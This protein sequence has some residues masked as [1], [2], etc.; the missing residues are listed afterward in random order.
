[1]SRVDNNCGGDKGQKPLRPNI[2]EEMM[3]KKRKASTEVVIGM[4]KYIIHHYKSEHKVF[5]KIKRGL[6]LQN[7]M[8][9]HYAKKRRLAC[10]K[11]KEALL[12]VKNLK[13]ENEHNSI[14]ILAEASQKLSKNI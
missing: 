7:K 2:K 10:A 4:E 3:V 5:K 9:K 6:A 14:G 13:R 12:E 1:M 11:L 8:T